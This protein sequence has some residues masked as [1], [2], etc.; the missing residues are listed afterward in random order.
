MANA[1]LPAGRCLRPSDDLASPGSLTR[2][3]PAAD[4]DSYIRS[5]AAL[6]V[7]YSTN[8]QATP[9]NWFSTH[10]GGR[11]VIYPMSA[12]NRRQERRSD[13]IDFLKDGYR[14]QE[15]IDYS[16]LE[17]DELFLEGTGAMVLD[18]IA[19]VAYVA[20][21][22][23]ANPIAVER[24]CTN[25]GYEPVV[26]DAHDENGVPIYHTNVMMCLG[27]DFAMIG[28]NSI[29]SESRRDEIAERLTASGRT[30]IDLDRRQIRNFAGNALE[31]VGI[32]G[33]L[34]VISRR[35]LKVLS[36]SVRQ[37]IGRRCELLPVEIP[38]IEEGGG[39]VRCMIAVVHL[40]P[41]KRP[42]QYAN[43][44]AT[45]WSTRPALNPSRPR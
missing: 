43:A 12:P 35:A 29:I 10:P 42:N 36:A 38:T 15:V 11:V 40:D 2:H 7:G 1:T 25:F 34:L 44:D 28:L 3:E 27:T 37:E 22:A 16:G 14:V 32:S 20:R 41:R 24:F 19:H 21:S 6:S 18:H 8:S 5:L 4:I 17:H 23:R 39:S 30:I 26:F 13:I 33:R 31:L 45:S 9:N